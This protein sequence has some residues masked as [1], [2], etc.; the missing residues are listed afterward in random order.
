[1]FHLVRSEGEQCEK[2]MIKWQTLD[3]MKSQSGLNV[4]R[5]NMYHARGDIILNIFILLQNIKHRRKNIFKIEHD[6]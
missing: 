4:P 5:S 1:M 3:T 2:Q 6:E